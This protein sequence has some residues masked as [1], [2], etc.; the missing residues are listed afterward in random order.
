MGGRGGGTTVASVGRLEE[1]GAVFWV[2]RVVDT[3]GVRVVVV[4]D[5]GS[6]N[7]RSV[8]VVVVVVD[9]FSATGRRVVVDVV[10]GRSILVFLVVVVDGS[11]LSKVGRSVE[12]VE[13]AG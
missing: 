12:V 1:R 6:T 3:I 7:D 9:N 11:R 8:V 4:V 10:I 2:E 13:Y 5:H